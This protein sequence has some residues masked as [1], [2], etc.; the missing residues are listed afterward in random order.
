[1]E[2]S[3][4]YRRDHENARPPRTWAAQRNVNP[5]TAE[6]RQN[7][8]LVATPIDQLAK[9]KDSPVRF[10]TVAREE[11]QKLA[12]RGQ[13]VQ[14]SR[15]QRRTLE[16]R[17]VD[18]TARKPGGVFEPAKVQLPRSPI[19]AK[20]ANQL[21][22]NRAPPQAQRAPKPDPQFQPKPE[23]AA[24]QPNPD[25]SNPRPQPLK[26]EPEKKLA[27]GRGEAVPRERQVQPDS[28]PRAKES[29][30]KAQEESERNASGLE[31]QVPPESQPRAKDPAM[32]APEKPQRNAGGL[33]QKTQRG[34]ERPSQPRPAAN[35]KG[36]AKLIKKD[37]K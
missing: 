7:R 31:K 16:A 14:K 2:S 20:S 28:P 29:G 8:V 5:T 23:T 11:R 18:T 36:A 25:R 26:P 37:R 33:E 13:E 30:A 12:Q 32:K 6:S 1:V 9:R 22:K 21:G 27:P 19:V 15:D 4:E 34:P 24:R 3:Y 17:A 10:Q 35:E